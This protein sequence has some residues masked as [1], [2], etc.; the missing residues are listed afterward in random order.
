MLQ[1]FSVV[2]DKVKRRGTY[3]VERSR[4][5]AIRFRTIRQVPPFLQWIIM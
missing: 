4:R 3:L 5:P 1:P 2:R